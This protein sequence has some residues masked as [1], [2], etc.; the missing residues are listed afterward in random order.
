MRYAPPNFFLC[1]Q[2]GAFIMRL[3]NMTGSDLKNFRRM[4]AFDVGSI[5]GS[6]DY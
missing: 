4:A 3:L 5:Q 2:V 1:L 6:N